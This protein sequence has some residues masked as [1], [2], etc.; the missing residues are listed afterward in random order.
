MPRGQ[1]KLL[2]AALGKCEVMEFGGEPAG[3]FRSVRAVGALPEHR[4]GSMVPLKSFI[5]LAAVDQKHRQVRAR[6]G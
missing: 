2:Q 1:I 6:V 5:G 4:K 3:Y